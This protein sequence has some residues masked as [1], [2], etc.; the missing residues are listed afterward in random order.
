MRA[1]GGPHLLHAQVAEGGVGGHGHED[2]RGDGA[3]AGVQHAGAGAGG[4]GG[5][6]LEADGHRGGLIPAR[7]PRARLFGG[8]L[9]WPSGLPPV[10]G[11]R[12]PP[13]A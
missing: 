7:R 6:E 11:P 5:D 8:P 9:A 13:W 1:P 10:Y 12:E 2:G 4:V 3:A